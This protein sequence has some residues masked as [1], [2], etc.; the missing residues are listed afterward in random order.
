MYS[1]AEDIIELRL[2]YYIQEEQLDVEIVE[3]IIWNDEIN[4]KIEQY[5]ENN[6]S[7]ELVGLYGTLETVK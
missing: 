6:H 2:V 1:Y 4:S 7:I 3:K 5:Q